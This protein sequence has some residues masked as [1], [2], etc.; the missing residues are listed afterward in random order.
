[1]LHAAAKTR[2]LYAAAVF[3]LGA[4]TIVNL[5]RVASTV[6]AAPAAVLD[7]EEVDIKLDWGAERDGTALACAVVWKA[8]LRSHTRGATRVT[9]EVAGAHTGSVED[10]AIAGC[11][12]RERG[13]RR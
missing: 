10:A 3:G 11:G 12:K 4:A 1:M 6:V 9:G 2:V 5:Q 7:I 13:H 8:V